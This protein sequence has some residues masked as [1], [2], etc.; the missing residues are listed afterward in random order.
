MP[1]EQKA[2]TDREL[3]ERAYAGELGEDYRDAACGAITASQNMPGE[4]TN[5]T[6]AEAIRNEVTGD[7]AA[8][9]QDGRR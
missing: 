9:E 1:D 2:R 8:A 5:A 6:I 7:S 4:W 3:I